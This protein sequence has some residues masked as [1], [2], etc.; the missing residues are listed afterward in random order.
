MHR[1]K[2]S[3]ASRTALKALDWLIHDKHIQW[4]RVAIM[5]VKYV[6]IKEWKRHTTLFFI[7]HTATLTEE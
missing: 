5:P 1:N 3:S 7:D 6:N 4:C 2:W